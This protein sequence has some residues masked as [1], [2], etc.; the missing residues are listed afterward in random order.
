VH[1]L[2]AY[3]F[4]FRSPNWLMNLVWGGLCFL[5]PIVGPMVMV[6]YL[7]EVIEWLHRRREEE[8]LPWVEPTEVVAAPE[9]AIRTEPG[10][11]AGDFQYA[12]PEQYPDFNVNRIQDYL[13]RGVWP[14]L[15]Q[16]V[17][18]LP[19]GMVLGLLPAAGGISVSVAVANNVHPLVIAAIVLV[20]LVVWVGAL[21]LVSVIQ[22]PL[23]LRAGL[24]RDFGSAFSMAFLKDFLKRVWVPLLLSQLFLHFTGVFAALAGLLLCLVGVYP[25]AAL[26]MMA[27]HHIDFQLYELYLQRGGEPILPREAR[28]EAEKSF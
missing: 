8:K 20:L 9:G 14:F 5:V 6:G 27:T 10:A 11:A 21:V 4:V 18:G 23:Y 16:L 13:M 7:F 24:R 17:V 3:R 12:A 25:A 1:Y 22:L 2:L 26:V 28:P 15:V 19:I